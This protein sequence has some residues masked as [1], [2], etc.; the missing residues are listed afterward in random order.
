MSDMPANCQECTYYY[1]THD[2]NFPH[3]CRAMDFKSRR[4]PLQE[5]IS[6]TLASCMSFLAKAR[7][8]D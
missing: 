1:I 5:V 6:T 2:A 3:G 8:N 7:Q 4:M